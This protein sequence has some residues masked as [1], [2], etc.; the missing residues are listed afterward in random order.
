MYIVTF[1]AFSSFT[2]VTTITTSFTS[3][4][5]D[6]AA[7]DRA[8]RLAGALRERSELLVPLLPLL[9]R[10]LVTLPVDE[11]PILLLG[12]DVT[13][14]INASQCLFVGDSLALV[15]TV[16]TQASTAAFAALAAAF[17]T[18]SRGEV[19]AS[20]SVAPSPVRGMPFY[21][22]RGGGDDFWSQT[23]GMQ[24][25]DVTRVAAAV[26]G[27]ALPVDVAALRMHVSPNG[28]PADSSLSDAAQVDLFLSDVALFMSQPA[29]QGE[30]GP[31]TTY[32]SD[33]VSV[34]V[35]SQGSLALPIDILLDVDTMRDRL[36]ISPAAATAAA[37]VGAVRTPT[38]P[39]E[40]LAGSLTDATRYAAHALHVARLTSAA[41]GRAVACYN[42]YASTVGAAAPAVNVVGG[43]PCVPLC[44]DESCGVKR[45]P[46]VTLILRVAPTS[47]AS[48]LAAAVDTAL[49]A[50]GVSPA[51][52]LPPLWQPYTPPRAIVLS[53]AAA[54]DSRRRSSSVSWLSLFRFR[55]EE[56]GTSISV[57]V[58]PFSDTFPAPAPD[59]IV[60]ALSE[61]GTTAA[62]GA[63]PFCFEGD[64]DPPPPSF[65][66]WAILVIAILSVAVILVLLC[67]WWKKKQRAR[68]EA[69]R[70]AEK[71]RMQPLQ[72]PE[73][74]ETF[75]NDD[76]V[77]DLDRAYSELR[78][79][80]GDK[81]KPLFS[82]QHVREIDALYKRWRNATR[83]AERLEII[84]EAEDLVDGNAEAPVQLPKIQETQFLMDS[85][86]AEPKR[87]SQLFAR[88]HV[89]VVPAPVPAPPSA[90]LEDLASSGATLDTAARWLFRPCTRDD[91]EQLLRAHGG[92]TGCFVVTQTESE[93]GET[94]TLS[95]VCHDGGICHRLIHWDDARCTLLLDEEH[96]PGSPPSLNDLIG[97][98]SDPALSVEG[99]DNRR[100]R[101][102][103]QRISTALCRPLAAGEIVWTADMLSIAE[104][105][106]KLHHSSHATGS[107][108][109]RHVGAPGEEE[110]MLFVKQ[111]PTHVKKHRLRLEEKYATIDGTPFSRDSDGTMPHTLSG[112][113]QSLQAGQSRLVPVRLGRPILCPRTSPDGLTARVHVQ[114]STTLQQA[115]GALE[116]LDL[117]GGAFLCADVHRTSVW[118][119]VYMPER[120]QGLDGA[121]KGAGRVRTENPTPIGAKHEPRHVQIRRD[122]AADVWMLGSK[123]CPK[124][125][126]TMADLLVALQ[127]PWPQMGWTTALAGAP[128]ALPLDLLWVT[129]DSCSVDGAATGLESTALTLDDGEASFEVAL[130]YGYAVPGQS[131]LDVAGGAVDRSTGMQRPSR[132]RANHARSRSPGVLHLH[133]GNRKHRSVS[134]TP[135]RR[136]PKR[137]EAA[138]ANDSEA[139]VPMPKPTQRTRV[140][141]APIAPESMPKVKRGAV[142]G[143]SRGV[144]APMG[145]VVYDDEP[146]PSFVGTTARRALG[147]SGDDEL[148]G[149]P[150][151]MRRASLAQQRERR[152]EAALGTLQWVQRRSSLEDLAS[153]RGSQ[154]PR[155]RSS[156]QDSYRESD[157]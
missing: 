80:I 59:R 39:V 81:A 118:H 62:S 105:E 18:Q 145:A 140:Q 51:A 101:R 35:N 108:L 46:V 60:A 95:F 116:R 152:G 15:A 99:L 114:P 67:C 38:A 88:S 4:V 84:A 2:L 143:D 121:A 115:A 130:N 23:P 47:S 117:M 65:P 37:E 28:E 42:V 1:T 144:P 142:D 11:P 22:R 139:G 154:G 94:A 127:C 129:R 83:D 27:L 132:R 91:A 5:V 150:E 76:R 125:I 6:G 136:A 100:I 73:H 106:Q 86:D 131:L 20:T 77:E 72:R 64:C 56:M 70:R 54:D 151:L 17:V 58:L 98:L 78:A 111:S 14:L 21:D 126:V 29:V 74:V 50:A 30:I 124:D 110:Y 49:L 36:E 123:P 141:L 31:T 41:S 12:N 156:A 96:I 52:G 85:Q 3:S 13:H 92:S 7:S 107:W 103:K 9:T 44:I 26:T 112:V 135:K 34:F 19:P 40:E 93:P 120:P 104:G 109:L 128:L 133:S 82:S 134:P 119:L 155:R 55:R 75:Y 146:E 157:V 66:V 61:T 153:S 122:P 137:A 48:V 63:D 16:G 148:P 69:K 68:R 45:T 32:S 43:S 24:A 79:I 53:S 10:Q 113:L 87:T 90:T 138:S 57:A 102:T 97:C 8:D 33:E 149:T 89:P 147:G 25:S 71:I